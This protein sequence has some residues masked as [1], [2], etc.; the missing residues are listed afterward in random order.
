MAVAGLVV[1]RELG[2]FGEPSAQVTEEGEAAEPSCAGCRQQGVQGVIHG[3]LSLLG[4][5]VQPRARCAL[6]WRLPRASDPLSLSALCIPLPL[7]LG[8][9]GSQFGVLGVQLACIDRQLDAL[10]LHL[11]EGRTQL[12]V[13]DHHSKEVG[14]ALVA[15]TVPY[16]ANAEGG[17]SIPPHETLLAQAMA[18]AVPETGRWGPFLLIIETDAPVAP[19]S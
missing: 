2:L 1:G 17:R 12:S 7:S 8:E 4:G 14:A 15:H 16:L 3:D 11:R 5:P 19:E 9:L 13:F 10:V 6:H 18:L